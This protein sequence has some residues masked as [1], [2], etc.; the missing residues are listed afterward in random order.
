MDKG[1]NII[2]IEERRMMRDYLLL[3]HMQEMVQ[4]SV[5]DLKYS[6]N[7]LTKAYTMSGNVIEDKICQDAK[8]LRIALKDRGIK[9]SQEE[10]DPNGFIIR[11]HYTCR[12]YTDKFAMTRD[13]MKSE[14][15]IRFSKYISDF[16][17]MLKSQ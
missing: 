4:K 8:A 12:G 2:T 6:G 13:V 14:I 15:S 1:A 9:V 11:Y 16:G 10:H 17:S 5:A 7:L 3:N